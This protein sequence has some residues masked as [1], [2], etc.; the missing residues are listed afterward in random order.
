MD[1]D[2][3][4]LIRTDGNTNIASGH[5]VRCITI[6]Q[7]VLK[8]G[9]RVHF[10][11]SDT[12][13]ER[14][15]MRR[16]ES[17]KNKAGIE[18]TVLGT[19]YQNLEQELP[20]LNALLAEL[21]EAVLLL[22]TYSVTPYYM[23]EVSKLAKV[24]YL[25][26]LQLFDYPVE[27]VINYDVQVDASFYQSAKCV[28]LEGNYAPLR[29]QFADCDYEVREYAC[30]L[31]LTTGGTDPER[32]CE[33]FVRYFWQQEDAKDWRIH[34]IVGSMFLN[35]E[36]LKDFADNEKRLILYEN[37]ENMAEVMA[38]CD[39]AVSAGGTTLFELC[40]IGVPTLSISISSNQVPCNEAFAKKGIL[41][42]EGHVSMDDLKQ[43]SL[44]KHM[45]AKVMELGSNLSERQQMSLRQKKAVDGRGAERIA[46]LLLCQ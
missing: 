11:V 9:G 1:Y 21:P 34:L 33:K 40:A 29:E 8:L 10:V 16:L 20:L 4:V 39:L 18:I 27:C 6:A 30:D 42:Y 13:S 23:R 43:D 14:E 38:V 35:K 37:V 15:L 45:Y 31:F 22:D 25:D 41:A 36:V 2:K 17:V 32:F 12:E 46:S 26:D 3:V 28:Y 5:L 19:D 44:I 24:F 7:A